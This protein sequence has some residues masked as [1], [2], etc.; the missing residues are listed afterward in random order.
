[1]NDLRDFYKGKRV[2]ITGHTGFKGAWLSLFLIEIGAEVIG[3]SLEPMT[4]K[5]LFVEARIDEIVT[6]IRGDIRNKDYL[7]SKLIEHKPEIIFHLAAQP[8]VIESYINPLETWEINVM[9]T[10]NLL[11]VIKKLDSVKAVVVV[12]TDKVYKNTENNIGYSEDDPLGGHDP[13]SSSK[14][15]VEL[16]VE[17]WRNSFFTN[18]E[19][20]VGI[21]TARAGN[22]IGGGD[23][24]ENRLIPDYFRAY[25]ADQVF[26]LRN[27]NSIRP[28][29]HVLDVTNGYAILAKRLYLEPRTYSLSYN[30]SSINNNEFTTKFIIEYLN[31][32]I[33]LD[34]YKVITSGKIFKETIT[35]KLNSIKALTFLEWKTNL[36][37]EQSLDYTLEYYIDSN[38]KSAREI[39]YTQINK[40]LKKIS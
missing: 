2:F 16:A 27:P 32:K 13:Y 34:D 11:E 15:A 19:V 36:S 9:G 38:N 22:V 26:E 28:W 37:L 33:L 40:F 12:T 7:E 1:V 17:S 25:F 24:A 30:F 23:W 29:Q 5:D 8:L 21:A 39:V 35:L 14:A 4:E 10:I 3:Y 31:R 6:D 18:S 20:P